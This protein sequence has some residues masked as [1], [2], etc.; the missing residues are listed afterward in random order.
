MSRAK[1]FPWRRVLFFASMI[2]LGS[3]IVVLAPVVWTWAQEADAVARVR[4]M[5]GVN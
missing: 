2:A 5:L 3:A 4:E 1:P